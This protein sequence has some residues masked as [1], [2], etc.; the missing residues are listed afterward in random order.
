MNVTIGD[1]FRGLG[2]LL[3]GFGFMCLPKFNM[4]PKRSLSVFNRTA[5]TGVWLQTGA[6]FMLA[7]AVVFLLAQV[8]SKRR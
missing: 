8:F 3:F 1:I 2:I 5:D 6:A 4:S 7:G